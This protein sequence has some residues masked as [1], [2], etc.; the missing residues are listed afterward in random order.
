MMLAILVEKRRKKI[1]ENLP[2]NCPIEYICAS[3]QI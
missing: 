1:E 2:G 3:V